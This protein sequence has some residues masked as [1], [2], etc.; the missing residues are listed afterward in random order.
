[1]KRTIAERSRL[2]Q[3]VVMSKVGLAV[4]ALLSGIGSAGANSPP[5]AARVTVVEAR[6]SKVEDITGQP[7]A[8]CFCDEKGNVLIDGSFRL[9]FTPIHI[10]LG[11]SLRTL[12]SYEQASAQPVVGYKYLL[13]VSHEETGDVIVWKGGFSNGLCLETDQISEYGLAGLAKR[14]P[15]RQ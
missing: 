4:V 9:S 6:L 1:M 3:H 13:V 12:P 10:L 15:C 8:P 5:E 11:K 7:G 14:L 2:S